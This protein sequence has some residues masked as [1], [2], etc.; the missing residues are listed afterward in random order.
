MKKMK[1]AL[2]L[3]LAAVMLAGALT[4]CK[5]SGSSAGSSAASRPIKA[6]VG[7][8]PKS[9]DPAINQS[10]D[11]AIYLSHTFEGLT[12]TDK[13]NKT[14]AGI[15]KSWDISDDELTYTFHLR[16]DAKWSDGKAVTAGDFVYAW[17]RAVNPSTASAYAYQLYYIKNAEAI[18]SQYV[19][20]DGK[21][22]KVKVG[23]DGKPV[24]DADGKYTEDTSGAYVSANAD[25]TA[26]WLDDLGVKATDDNTLV[27]TL[28]APCAYF[29]QIAGFATLDPVREDIVEANPDSWASDPSTYICDGPYIVKSWD[30]NSKIVM[31]ENPYYYDKDNIVGAELDWMLMDD[32]NSI[33]AAFKNGELDLAQDYPTDELTSLIKSGDAKTY[34]LLGIYYYAFND[35]KEPFDNI[36]VREALTL[37]IDRDYLVSNISKGGEKVAGSVV[38]YGIFDADGKSDYRKTA[39]ELMDVSKD[40]NEANIAKAKKALTEAGYPDGKG[41]PT[42]TIK[43]NTLELHQ[44]VAEYI[45]S[46]WKKNLGINVNIANEQW[47]VFINDRNTGNFDVARDGWN[48]DYADPMTFLDIFTSTSGNNDSKWKNT[49]FDKLI[50]D[51]KSTGD[52]E[53]RMTDMHSAEKILIDDYACMP[54]YYYTDPDLVSSKLKG[55]VASPMGYK[56]LMWASISE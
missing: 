42:I 14:V 28:T 17:Q 16:T 5:S 18:N 15:A 30:H 10:V 55:Y 2:S 52:Q 46:E 44:K 50:S 27:V 3:A 41:F 34:D 26:I 53:K 9:I 29:L 21:P 1:K 48:A 11:G 35:S 32:A 47:S 56:F 8:E 38:P 49:S 40:S 24:T 7:S 4:G 37:A 36:K 51:A 25:G 12:K 13:N 20:S 19:G 33:L 22:A 39:G 54:I 31:T 43:F 23:S 45:Q 6:C